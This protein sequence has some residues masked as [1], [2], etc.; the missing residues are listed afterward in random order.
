MGRRCG[1]PGTGERE[2]QQPAPS[3]PPP[4]AALRGHA[5][6][7]PRPFLFRPRPPAGRP[8]AGTELGR[9]GQEG[10]GGRWRA[11]AGAAGHDDRQPGRGRRP[12]PRLRAAAL[13]GGQ[14]AV[15]AL[16]RDLLLP[17]RAGQ[18][19][20][21]DHLPVRRAPGGRAG[22]AGARLLGG[23]RSRDLPA[24]GAARGPA[25]GGAAGLPLRSERFSRARGT[26]SAESPCRLQCR[27]RCTT[28]QSF[29]Y[30]ETRTHL[31]TAPCCCRTPRSCACRA[32]PQSFQMHPRAETSGLNVNFQGE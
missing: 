8:R 23:A 18:Q 2:L 6:G 14:T 3:A 24:P 5:L 1:A 29:Y 25:G 13:P 10:G 20:A 22:A 7:L 31:P 19:G 17:H 4:R 21:A 11:A 12:G 28:Q 26:Q 9:G 16:L 27:R 30:R 32:T 15:G